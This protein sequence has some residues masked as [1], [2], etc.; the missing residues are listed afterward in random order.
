MSNR[1]VSF[2]FPFLGLVSAHAGGCAG[3][4]QPQPSQEQQLARAVAAPARL[5]PPESLPG[6][7][8]QILR[9]RMISHARDMGELVSAIMVLD[10]E[11]IQSRAQSIAADVNL[12]R[13]ITQDATELNSALP[14]KFFLHQ[15]ALRLQ[16]GYLANAAA[17]QSAFDVASAYGTVAQTCVQCHAT[18]RGE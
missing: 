4:Q 11:R 16:A 10:Y 18:Y 1:T 7:A 3:P 9:Q 2:V 8:R 15:D 12:S 17:R 14:E 5:K 13:P 6:A